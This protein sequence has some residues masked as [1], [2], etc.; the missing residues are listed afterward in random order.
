MKNNIQSLVK[1][2]WE[3]NLE[4]VWE[5]FTYKT[6]FGIK[7]YI[8]GPNSGVENEDFLTDFLWQICAKHTKNKLF[9]RITEN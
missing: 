7:T 3:M 5:E 1:T 9:F 4:I 2:V 6:G 8:W